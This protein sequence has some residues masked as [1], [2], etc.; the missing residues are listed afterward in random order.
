MDSLAALATISI[1]LVLL[2]LA[3][4]GGMFVL[5]AFLLIKLMDLRFRD[6][7]QAVWRIAVDFFRGR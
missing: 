4:A 3:C 2:A 7:V 6:A 5:L 1:L